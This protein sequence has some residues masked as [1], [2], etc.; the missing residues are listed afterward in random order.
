MPLETS[1]DQGATGRPF[2]DRSRPALPRSP[3]SKA[4]G[5]MRWAMPKPASKAVTAVGLAWFPMATKD[6]P[7]WGASQ[8]ACAR[9]GQAQKFVEARV[10]KVE[11]GVCV[12]STE[13]LTSKRAL[14]E[15]TL[16]SAAVRWVLRAWSKGDNRREVAS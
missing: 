16:R 6:N 11:A 13:P 10:F 14:S 8:G 12:V 2:P 15:V 3:A 4:K 9:R 7:R 5:P 1:V